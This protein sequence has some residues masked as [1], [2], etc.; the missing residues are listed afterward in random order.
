[1]R[2][3]VPFQLEDVCGLGD[4]TVDDPIGR[5]V[6]IFGYE[7]GEDGGDGGPDLRRFEQG[8]ASGGYGT[9]DGL[10][11]EKEGEVPWHDAPGA[12]QDGGGPRPLPVGRNDALV[13]GPFVELLRGLDGASDHGPDLAGDDFETGLSEVG[14][15]GLDD[16]VD[17]LAEH[18]DELV[19]L[20]LAPGDGT[21]G[22]SAEG[23]L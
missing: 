5:L 12:L 11:A 4:G 2:A 7:I 21:R 15:E 6:E 3:T 9:D 19:Q 1:M 13:A 22:P 16:G 18:E 17:V 14:R 20:D 10:E 8:G 23:G